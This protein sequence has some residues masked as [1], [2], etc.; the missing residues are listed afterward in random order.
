MG[1]WILGNEDLHFRVVAGKGPYS[2]SGMLRAAQ[3]MGWAD[4]YASHQQVP[5]CY[6]H[7]GLQ[8]QP[9]GDDCSDLACQGHQ[10]L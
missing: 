6:S 3:L 7:F 9:L 8:L 2:S 1:L 4:N 5:M 10:Q